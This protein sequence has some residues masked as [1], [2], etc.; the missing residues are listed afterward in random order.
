MERKN[1]ECEALQSFWKQM[2][3]QKRRWKNGKVRFSCGQRCTR[4]VLEHKEN[5]QK[6]FQDM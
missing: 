1:N 2:I 5:I 4:W 3:H 6:K